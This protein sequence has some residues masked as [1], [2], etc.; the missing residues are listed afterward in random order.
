MKKYN[1][2]DKNFRVCGL[3]F[4]DSEKGFRRLPEAL[5]EKIPALKDASARPCGARLLFKTN[6]K[7]IKI[8]IDLEN[9]YVDRGFA[10]YQSNVAPVF[11]GERTGADFAGIITADNTYADSR[12]TGTFANEGENDVVVYLPRNPTVTD[13]SICL[14]DDAEVLPPTPFKTE[15]PIVF[16]GSS[17][18]ENGHCGAQNAYNALVARE[19]DADY[20]NLGF[21]GLARG[22]IEVAEFICSIEHG[23]FVYDYDHNA[24]N[25]EHLAAT[26]YPFYKAYREKCPDTPVIMMTRPAYD[27]PTSAE[28]LAIV[29]KSYEKGIKDGDKNLYFIDGKTLFGDVL[30]E[31]CTT[32]RTHPNDL[33]HYLM[34]KRVSEV[35]KSFN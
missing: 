9:V 19:L 20:Y 21:S 7:T 5:V 29:R 12:I 22:E 11:I 25:P 24:P 17:I 34:Y 10:F 2:K 23:I 33:G 30:P 4:F 14:D 13:I 28:R 3:A 1:Y 18:V 16:Y 32:D 15:K 27:D 35:I 6:S 8:E 26:H 31:I